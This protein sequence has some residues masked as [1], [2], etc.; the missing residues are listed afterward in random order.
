MNKK[1]LLDDNVVID[2][3]VIQ[4]FFDISKLELLFNTFTKISIPREVYDKEIS[5]RVQKEIS[6]YS[7][8]IADI[9]TSE[10][11]ITLA[12]LS[13][14][15]KYRRLSPFDRI[16]ISIAK[17][18]GVFCGSNDNPI[19]KACHDFSVDV[20]GTLGVLGRNFHLGNIDIAELNRL[21]NLLKSDSTSC[22]ITESVIEEF[23]KNI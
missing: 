8:S 14:N 9:N 5:D 11:Y 20:I 4:D 10:G 6:K 7:Y 22:Y 1:Y 12:E 18:K 19:R 16:V 15:K 23:L 17:E 13:S 2:N 21:V 3:N